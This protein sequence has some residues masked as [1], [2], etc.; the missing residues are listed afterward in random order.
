VDVFALRGRAYVPFG[1][2]QATDTARSEL[3]PEVEAALPEVWGER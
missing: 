3:L 2:F 1:H